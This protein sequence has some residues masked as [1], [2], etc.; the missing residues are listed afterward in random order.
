MGKYAKAISKSCMLGVDILIFVI[1]G[2]QDKGFDRMLNEIQELI[3]DGIIT[4]KVIVQAGCT[5]F[6]SDE[7]D[8]IDYLP[9][10]KFNEYI[11]KADIVITHGGVGSI[12]DS[13]KHHK[14]VIAI[15]RLE[16]YHEHVNDHQIQ[17]VEEF[18]RLG[19]IMDCGNL[20]RLGNKLM[21]IEK[22]TP[23]PFVSNNKKFIQKLEEY[24]SD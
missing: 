10:Q 8:I 3:K 14:K 24:I 12:L 13:I 21:E 5:D 7:M 17:I 4:K 1:L 6:K 18:D 11:E 19:Y 20:K 16:K 22:F 23:T 15:P 2:T 9:M